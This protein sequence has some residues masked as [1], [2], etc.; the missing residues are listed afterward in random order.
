MRP[1]IRV[2]LTSFTKLANK[3][4]IQK[5]LRLKVFSTVANL[6]SDRD[7]STVLSEENQ[8]AVLKI[9]IKI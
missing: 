7:Q 8:L 3:L 5:M 2:E 6:T 9:G 1:C 4:H